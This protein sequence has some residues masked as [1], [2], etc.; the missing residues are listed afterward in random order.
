MSFYRR[1]LPHWQPAGAEYFITFRLTGSL[2][3]EVIENL[4]QEKEKLYKKLKN[5]YQ[6]SANLPHPV[7]NQ[8]DDGQAGLRGIIQRKIFKKYEA[9]L[10]KG[11]FGPTWLKQPDIVAI[12]K[13][14]IHFRDHKEFELY[15]Y[16]I[17]SNH[18]HLVFRHLSDSV[19]LNQNEK[20]FPITDIMESLKNLRRVNVINSLIEPEILFGK[21]RATI[22]LSGIQMNWSV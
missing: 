19:S 11:N 22:M 21:P 2:P 20:K 3:K 1:N 16:C 10:D 5:N 18:V 12:I 7:R 17:M 6:G 15:A 9:V 4:Q 13:K 14:S 8:S